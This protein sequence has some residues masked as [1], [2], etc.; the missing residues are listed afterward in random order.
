MAKKNK[1]LD[2]QKFAGHEHVAD[3][4]SNVTG[5]PIEGVSGHSL[6]SVAVESQ[7]KL[8]DDVGRGNPVVMRSFTFKI[9]KTAFLSNKPS[10]QELFDTH[11]RGIEMILWRDGL[12]F[13]KRWE[14]RIL[15]NKK[16]THYTIF[17]VATPARG[18][19]L[20]DQT[21]TLSELAHG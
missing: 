14:P 2:V 3:V 13:E 19:T 11:A 4:N 17:V 20:V 5:S 16:A 12:T 10:K 9:N 21:R 15:F 8:E 18:Q 6:E 7:T 1:S